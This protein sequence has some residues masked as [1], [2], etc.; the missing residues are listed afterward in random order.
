LKDA[1]SL[2]PEARHR[3]MRCCTPAMQSCSKLERFRLKFTD[4]AQ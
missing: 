3:L 4:Q 2:F 1:G